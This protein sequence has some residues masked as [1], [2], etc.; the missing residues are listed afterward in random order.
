[1]RTRMASDADVYRRTWLHIRETALKAYFGL[2]G[3]TSLLDPS[4]RRPQVTPRVEAH[5]DLFNLQWHV[6]PCVAA[7]PF[8][9][10][11]CARLYQRAPAQFTEPLHHGPSVRERLAAGHRQYQ[12]RIVAVEATMKPRYLP[13][14]RQHYGSAHGFDGSADPLNPY[15]DQA[16]LGRTRYGHNYV[17]LR[18]LVQLI[19]ADWRRRELVP[20]G[21]RVTLCPPV[22]FNLI[23]TV[24]H[25]EWSETESL[26]VGYYA[27]D[28]SAHCYVVGANGLM[29]FS[30]VEPVEPTT[31]WKLLGF[32]IALVPD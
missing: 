13:D 9:E 27:E 21:Y 22:V 5:L 6:I 32:R 1:M 11:Y 12:G 29:D 19:T 4:T 24:F 7:V 30:Y 3:E 14:R 16:G 25:P 15:L 8:D 28:Q 26:E 17:T 20:V 2:D 10:S 31:D 18:H 23:G